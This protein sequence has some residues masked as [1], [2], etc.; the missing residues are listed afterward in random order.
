MGIYLHFDV[1]L[2][3]KFSAGRVGSGLYT[4]TS[5]LGVCPK[6]FRFDYW[7]LRL[8]S[9]VLLFYPGIPE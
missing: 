2:H 9:T 4:R 8:S 3:L 5:T 6:G 1:Y 7:G